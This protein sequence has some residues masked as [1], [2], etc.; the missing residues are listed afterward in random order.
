MWFSFM[1]S[2]NYVRSLTMKLTIAAHLP[3]WVLASVSTWQIKISSIKGCGGIKTKRE[4]NIKTSIDHICPRYFALWVS[5]GSAKKSL[6]HNYLF[7][8][9]TVP[10]A[11]VATIILQRVLMFVWL[12]PPSH[13]SSH[14]HSKSKYT[15]VQVRPQARNSSISHKLNLHKVRKLFIQI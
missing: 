14:K 3:L 4:D 5:D 6:L 13:D 15:T 1:S 11:A 8:L 7:S 2:L 12:L 9:I 10:P